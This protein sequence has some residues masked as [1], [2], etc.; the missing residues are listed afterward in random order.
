MKK[1][2]LLNLVVLCAGKNILGTHMYAG[3]SLLEGIN[4]RNAAT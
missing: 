1:T 2:I 3:Q 4:F